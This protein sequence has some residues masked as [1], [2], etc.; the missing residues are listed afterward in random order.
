MTASPR[1]DTLIDTSRLLSP[2]AGRRLKAHAVKSSVHRMSPLSSPAGQQ[3]QLYSASCSGYGSAAGSPS[4]LQ[5]CDNSNSSQQ[6]AMTPVKSSLRSSSLASS[7]SFSSLLEASIAS[8][9]LAASAGAPLTSS[10]TTYG[11]FASRT[12][13]AQLRTP[14]R[15]ASTII[16]SATGASGFVHGSASAAH[17]GSGSGSSS[18]QGSPSLAL[19]SRQTAAMLSNGVTLGRVVHSARTPVKANSPKLL[20]GL[21]AKADINGLAGPGVGSGLLPRLKQQ[22]VQHHGIGAVVISPG[23]RRSKAKVTT[24]DRFIPNRQ[25]MDMAASHFSSLKDTIERPQSLDPETMAYQEQLAKSCGVALDQRILTFSLEPPQADRTDMRATW[26][27]PLRQPNHRVAKRRIPTCP[28]KVLDAPGLVDDF[29]LNLLDEFCQTGE[30]DYI[31]SVEFTLDGSHLAVATSAGDAQIWDVDSSSKV[32]TM[33]GRN[34]RVGVLSWDK[35]I[36]S[37]GAR[38]GSIWHHDVRV[39]NHK[40]AELLGHSSEVCGLEWRPDGQMLASGGNDNLVNIWD[41][42]STT[43]RITKSDHMAAVKAIAWCPW[44]LN[45][46]ATGGGSSDQTVHFW[47]TTTSGKVSSVHTGS[48][49][50][51]IIW[52]R[53]YKEFL[54]SHGFP[55]NQLS[56][57]GYPSLTKIADLAGHESRVLHTTLSPD[58]QM[59]ASSASDESL[60][61]WKVFEAPKGKG[62]SAGPGGVPGGLPKSGLG[63]S[64]SDGH[65]M[66]DVLTKA[67]SR[68][69]IR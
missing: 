3:R 54:T 29:Y 8:G 40:V 10:P 59:V 4:K 31:S 28:E 19:S 5:L 55:N 50:T 45:L 30:D 60:K 25:T 17:G 42:R 57:W 32:R 22:T 38:D 65:A 68:M 46:L 2:R 58:G 51:S 21:V 36:L 9:S 14:Q 49:V 12:A 52:S 43:P 67:Y 13:G 39:A 41:V 16:S 26:Q 61:F 18:S 24:Y 63:P 47:N 37:A 6:L 44:Q 35:H 66:D 69:T 15:G 62:G 23:M 11:P 53:Q 48:Q 64:G 20:A 1:A 33:R 7:T 56:I 34:S 27:R